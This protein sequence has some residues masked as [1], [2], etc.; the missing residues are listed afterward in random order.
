LKVI[1]DLKENCPAPI[2]EGEKR[3]KS[4][5]AHFTLITTL[6]GRIEAVDTELQ[7]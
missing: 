1:E 3:P 6:E 2:K 5:V 7:V 4:E